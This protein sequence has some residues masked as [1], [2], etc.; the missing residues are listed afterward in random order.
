M[1]D[2]LGAAGLAVISSQPGKNAVHH[3]TISQFDLIV[4]DTMVA[5]AARLCV[6][7]LIEA[8]PATPPM[9]IL[10]LSNSPSQTI[11]MAATNARIEYLFRPFDD[12]FLTA[13]INTMLAQRRNPQAA[14]EPAHDA[15]KEAPLPYDKDMEKLIE[16]LPA[17]VEDIEKKSVQTS[18]T[19]IELQS[20]VITTLGEEA[21]K[22]LQTK[23]TDGQMPLPEEIQKTADKVDEMLRLCASVKPPKPQN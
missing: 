19:N 3:I 9:P 7:R 6:T 10:I 11:D 20:G 4:I 13:K 12:S 1:I 8:L 18:L 16:S 5:E 2:S 21:S 15:V 17:T 22:A 14:H 23:L